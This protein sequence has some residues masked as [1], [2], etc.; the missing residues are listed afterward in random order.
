MLAG[1]RYKQWLMLEVEVNT[2]V[3]NFAQKKEVHRLLDGSTASA[4]FLF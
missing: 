4:M 1:I 3:Y 2:A